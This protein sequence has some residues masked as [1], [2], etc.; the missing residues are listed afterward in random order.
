M[1]FIATFSACISLLASPLAGA[2]EQVLN[3]YSAR[4]YATDEALYSNFTKD[5]WNPHP[6][7]RLG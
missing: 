6:A 1:K 7:R 2:Q 4:H 3:L 5:D